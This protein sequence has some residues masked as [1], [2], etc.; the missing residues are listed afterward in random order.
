M[1][2]ISDAASLKRSHTHARSRRS[3]HFARGTSIPIEIVKESVLAN[4]PFTENIT[5]ELKTASDVCQ[6]DEILE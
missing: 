6:Y 1:E 3:D 5:F 4:K 2:I